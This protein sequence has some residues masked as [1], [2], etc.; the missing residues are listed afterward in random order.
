[1]KLKIY[2]QIK[3]NINIVEEETLNQN[4][5]LSLSFAKKMLKQD[6]KLLKIFARSRL[7]Q[8]GLSFN[9]IYFELDN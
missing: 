5:K 2:D 8:N 7:A 9:K 4:Q 6:N 3:D 1:M